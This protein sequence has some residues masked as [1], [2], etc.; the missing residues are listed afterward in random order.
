MKH[1]TLL[2]LLL[3]NLFLCSNAQIN[4]GTYFNSAWNKS[5]NI[6][7]S[8]LQNGSED[9]NLFIG[10]KGELENQEDNIIIKSTNIPEFSLFLR[11]VRDKFIE[12]K[13]V[14]QDNNVRDMN[15]EM[16]F[17]SPRVDIGW[18][19]KEWHFAIGET[20]KPTFF[21]FKDGKC[22]VSMSKKVTSSS[23]K[24][25]TEE[26]FF[27]FTNPDEITELIKA[28]RKENILPKL[29]SNSDKLDLFH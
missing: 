4:V 2:F 20:L 6:Q 8:E 29:K 14:A 1:Q 27:V 13:K 11:Q 15:K 3:A 21:V 25:I 18:S 24:Y 19:Y 26:V 9:F 23:N 12:W 5:F 17:S 28:I 16:D 10:I 7:A 22:S